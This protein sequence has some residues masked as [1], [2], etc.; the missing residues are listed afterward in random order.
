[1]DKTVISNITPSE[2]E[3][4]ETLFSEYQLTMSEL[5]RMIWHYE[6]YGSFN[7][8]RP[9]YSDTADLTNLNRKVA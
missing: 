7:I 1:M 4:A 6:S 5:E 3:Q 9:N 8:V 2:I